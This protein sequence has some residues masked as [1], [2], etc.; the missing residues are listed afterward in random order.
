MDITKED[1]IFQEL[2]AKNYIT[3]ISEIIRTLSLLYMIIPLLYMYSN[4][5]D[6]NEL[7]K[8]E[9]AIVIWAIAILLLLSL[10]FFKFQGE[11]KN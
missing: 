2:S 1:K 8:Y 10:I 6:K 9:I 3:Y 4:V 7:M 11:Q 5:D